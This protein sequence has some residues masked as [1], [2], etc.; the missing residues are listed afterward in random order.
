MQLPDLEAGSGHLIHGRPR[1]RLRRRRSASPG[2]TP[3]NFSSSSPLARVDGSNPNIG[4]HNHDFIP[5]AI[6]F[7]SAAPAPAFLSMQNSLL[8]RRSIHPSLSRHEHARSSSR[9]SVP[10]VRRTARAAACHHPRHPGRCTVRLCCTTAA[11]ARQSSCAG[12]GC[13]A[14]GAR[15]CE[16]PGSRAA[17]CAARA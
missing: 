5:G 15:A 16:C 17:G 1:L 11:P 7:T 12:A 13:T 10:S 9:S 6:Q 4:C 3:L 2:R 14:A 8:A